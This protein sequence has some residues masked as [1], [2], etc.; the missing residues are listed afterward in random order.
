MEKQR[1]RE[2]VWRLLQ[3]HKVSS[4]PGAY[5]RS[6]NFVGAEAAAA[7]LSELDAWR[8]AKVIKADPDLPQR[9][10]RRLALE[11]GKRLFMA[12]PRLR[13]MTPFIELDLAHLKASP[14]E[15]SSIGGASRAGRAVRVEGLP[16]TD[17]IVC[18]SVAVTMEGGRLGKGDGYSD[19]ESGLLIEAGKVTQ[20]TTILTAVH[21]FQSVKDRFDVLP[22]DISV[23]VIV[24]PDE[25]IRIR[26]RHP[27]PKGM[28]RELLA[29]EKLASVPLLTALR[30]IR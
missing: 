20:R 19:L 2:T 9:P 14:F 7:R 6:P 13:S 26:R 27:R 3:E 24:T 29:T 5:G 1:V 10:V 28:Y 22:R 18:G 17:L 30:P 23:D 25:I 11:Q 21:P 12:V 16:P 4:F 8:P 15:A